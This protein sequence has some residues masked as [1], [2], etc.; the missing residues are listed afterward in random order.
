MAMEMMVWISV[1]LVIATSLFIFKGQVISVLNKS[2]KDINALN[3][4][5]NKL[6]ESTTKEAIVKNNST[7]KTTQSITQKQETP[8][9]ETKEIQ[10]PT[11]VNNITNNNQKEYNTVIINE[12]QTPTKQDNSFLTNLGANLI[13]ELVVAILFAG[14][15]WF[16]RDYLKLRKHQKLNMKKD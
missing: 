4:E 14:L 12:S 15:T 5:E 16:I 10:A 11:V 7:D 8:K 2:A 6:N 1:V 13:A 9:Q 3:V